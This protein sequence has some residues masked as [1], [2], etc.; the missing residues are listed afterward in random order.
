VNRLTII[1]TSEANMKTVN[2]I[3]EQESQLEGIEFSDL[4][5]R[6]TPQD[7]TDGCGDDNDSNASDDDF[8]IDEEY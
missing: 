7:F 6:I 8:K 4:N 5:G 2:D 3:G 1:P